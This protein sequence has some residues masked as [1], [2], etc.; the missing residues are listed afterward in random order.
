MTFTLSKLPTTTYYICTLCIRH[1]GPSC[2]NT[3]SKMILPTYEISDHTCTWYTFVD[4]P[5][6]GTGNEMGAELL[7]KHR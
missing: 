5:V 3:A 6:N 2:M 7:I 1:Y 4:R